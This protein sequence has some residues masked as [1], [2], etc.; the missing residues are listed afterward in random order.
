MVEGGTAV[1]GA[2]AGLVCNGVFHS[3]AMGLGG[4]FLMTA[5]QVQ[6]RPSHLS[7]HD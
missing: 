7:V 2:V 5:Y 1:D 6:E 3:Q 4:G